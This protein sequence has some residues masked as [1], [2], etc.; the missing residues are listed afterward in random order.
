MSSTASDAVVDVWWLELDVDRH[1]LDACAA[2]LDADDAARVDALAT[3]ELRRR[4]TVRLGQRRAVLADALGVPADRLE[5]RSEPSGRPYVVAPDG[6]R[7]AVGASSRGD[8]GIV[9]CSRGATVGVDV[10]AT[11]ELGSSLPVLE[12][13]ASDAERQQLEGLDPPA[14]SRA[15]LRLWTRKEALLK[16][17]GVGIGAGMAHL[18]VGIDDSAGV[19]AFQ[20]AQGGDWWHCHD[21]ACPN[22]ELAA[23][24][25]VSATSPG[26][27]PIEVRISTR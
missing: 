21:L 7:V 16:A 23:A 11:S 5:L 6:G 10:E 14:L 22:N 4:M 18:T 26:D 1:V 12:R 3:E 15:V 25:V 20:P 24:L 17:T 2:L 8:V 9:A 27:P 19:V 13:I